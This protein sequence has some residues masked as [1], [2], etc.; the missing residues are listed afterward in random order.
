MPLTSLASYLSTMQEF[1]THWTAVNVDLGAGGPL[2]LN[3]PYAVADLTA[4]RT[5]LQTKITAVEAAE[6]N[7]QQWA[8]ERDNRKAPLLERVRQFRAMVQ[9]LLRTSPF[10]QGLPLQPSFKDAPGDVLKALD[11]MASLWSNINTSPPDGFTG[12]LKLQGGYL[13]A[14]FNTDLGLWRAALTTH[15]GAMQ[16]AL[17]AR[18]VRNQLLP[19]I[20]NHLVLYR[21]AVMGYYAKGHAMIES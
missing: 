18:E 19:P 13:L 15:D 12:P 2:V 11:D 20:K 8:N 6:N 7:A 5:A 4:S 9:G 17:I 1:I 16:S 14:T 3:G 21:Q 10:V